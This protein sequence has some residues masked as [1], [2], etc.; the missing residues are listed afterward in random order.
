MIKGI[1]ISK[2]QKGLKLTEVKKAGYEFVILRGAFTGYGADR[3]KQ[4]DNCFDDFYKQ[5]KNLGL[6]VGVYYYSCARTRA[7]GISEA[8]FLYNQCLKGKTFE[9]PIYIDVEDSKWQAGHRKGV[10]DAIIGF[11]EELERLGFYSGVYSSLSWFNTMLETDRLA[12]WT[13]WVARWITG[14]NTKP[15]VG[16]NAFDMWQYT[17]NGRV[18]GKQVDE[19]ICYIDFETIIKKVGKNGY[20]GTLASSQPKHEAKQKLTQATKTHIVK[21]GETLSKIAKKYKTTVPELVA[22]NNIKDKN[23]IY[24]GQVLKI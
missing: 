4:K 23:K 9:M 11:C 7:E 20:N 8:Q 22:K 17:D 15:V 1:D 12:G 16:F 2:H 18:G 5:A 21:K 13:K 14:A 6:K 24:V 10:T 19:D 3:T